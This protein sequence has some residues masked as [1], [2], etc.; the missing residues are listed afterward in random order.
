[1]FRAAHKQWKVA[2]L[3]LIITSAPIKFRIVEMETGNWLNL[4]KRPCWDSISDPF[5]FEAN[6]WTAG[7]CY[8]REVPA[9]LPI[10]LRVM[11]SS[12]IGLKFGVL[13]TTHTT[14]QMRPWLFWLRE[15]PKDRQFEPH[16]GI[17]MV[18]ALG[19][20]VYIYGLTKSSRCVSSP[21]F[22]FSSVISLC[23][24]CRNNRLLSKNKSSGSCVSLLWLK[25]NWKKI[26]KIFSWNSKVG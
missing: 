5:A 12:A 21:I 15:K 7:L 3:I 19:S 26:C 9:K 24:R 22:S 2:I 20:L 18:Q 16:V 25:L 6:I 4:N 11:A 8:L 10:P 14:K 13:P 1:M 17:K 23:S